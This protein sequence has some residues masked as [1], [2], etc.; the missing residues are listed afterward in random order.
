MSSLLQFDGKVDRRGVHLE[1]YQVAE[2]YAESHKGYWHEVSGEYLEYTD[3]RVLPEEC[4]QATDQHTCSVCGKLHPRLWV[5]PRKPAGMF[6]CWVV[7]R[8]NGRE[9]VPDLSCPIAT[10][11]IPRGAKRLS[12]DESSK[13]WHRG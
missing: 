8:Y 13:L 10:Y 2:S 11:K 6:G 9:N 7:F 1:F 12:D 3:I 4:S 5:A